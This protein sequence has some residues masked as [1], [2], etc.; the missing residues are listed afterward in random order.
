M[1]FGKTAQGQ[2]VQCVTRLAENALRA[3]PGKREQKIVDRA[4]VQIVISPLKRCQRFKVVSLD[5]PDHVFIKRR[6]IT[7]FAKSAVCA[8]AACATCNLACFCGGQ[9]PAATSIKFSA[10]CE[11]DVFDIKIEPHADGVRGDQIVNL[12]RLIKV[13]LG[14]AGSGRQRAHNDRRSAP[15]ALQKLGDSVNFF[16]RKRHDSRALG[17]FGRLH[18]AD[19]C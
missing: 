8:E 7:C 17:K 5:T 18:G 2:F 10:A 12:A 3:R 15:L 9:L 6:T 13:H 19:I 1:I 16:C 14:V 11:G 4:I